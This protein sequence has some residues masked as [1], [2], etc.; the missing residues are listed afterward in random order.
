MIGTFYAKLR[1]RAARL[2]AGITGKQPGRT[3]FSHYDDTELTR[4]DV[5]T[6]GHRAVIGGMWE[7]IGTLQA[8]FLK[9]QGLR[10]DHVFI[11]V[12][13]GGFRAGVKLIPYL[14][15]GNYY[16]ID[17]QALLLEEG[18]R[19]EIEPAGLAGRF[20]R[21]NFSATGSFDISGFGCMFDIGIA[22][23]VFTH[24]PIGMLNDCLT[25]IAPHFRPGGRFFATVFLAPEVEASGQFTQIPGGVVSAPDRDPFHT[26]LSALDA[27][28]A[29]APGWTMSV[30]GDWNHPRNQ[31]M[32]C[33][34]RTG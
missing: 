31:R 29:R 25:A 2:A 10:P 33:C 27:V 4:L 34:V 28:A 1:H 13:S 21:G 30:I 3:A 12:G 23:S 9:A 20:P 14:D 18:Y 11:D 17:L 5:A 6:R 8:D 22:Q 7:E 26:T 19:Q 24:M 16:A 32:I 15:P